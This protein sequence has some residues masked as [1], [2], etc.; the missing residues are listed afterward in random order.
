M[1]CDLCRGKMDVIGSRNEQNLNEID[2][3]YTCRKCDRKIRITV[4]N[5]ILPKVSGSNSR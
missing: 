3:F 1:K 4:T 2:R 5:E